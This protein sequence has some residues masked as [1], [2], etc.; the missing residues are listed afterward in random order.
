MQTHGPQEILNSSFRSCPLRHMWLGGEA[1]R[2]TPTSINNGRASGSPSAAGGFE[3]HHPLLN[4]FMN[5]GPDSSRI[6]FCCCKSRQA[7]QD[8]ATSLSNAGSRLQPQSQS[9]FTRLLKRTTGWRAGRPAVAWAGAPS[10]GSPAVLHWCHQCTIGP[11]GGV[12]AVWQYPDRDDPPGIQGL[13][14]EPRNTKR[15]QVADALG[16]APDDSTR[17]SP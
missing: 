14:A 6:R 15:D 11:S 9:C 10:P 16:N 7:G 13:A 8:R 17:A 2:E 3:S 12:C 1:W 5:M 4:N